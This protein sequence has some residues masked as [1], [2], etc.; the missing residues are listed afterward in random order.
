MKRIKEIIFKCS[1]GVAG[2]GG[3][4]DD[5]NCG[6]C[7]HVDSGH[8]GNKDKERLCRFTLGM[9]DIVAN[10]EAP[11]A[12]KVKLTIDGKDA[13]RTADGA[14][15]TVKLGR[16]YLEKDGRLPLT[17][18]TEP[19]DAAKALTIKSLVFTPA[20][21]G[22]PVV[23]SEDLSITL[24]ARDS[25]VHGRTL[26]YEY[27][28]DKNTLGYWGNEKDWV[29]WEFELKK[30]GKFIVFVMHGSGGGS[31]IEIA[32]DEQKLN[33]ITKIPGISH[34]Y[35]SRG[36]HAHSHQAGPVEPDFEANQESR[37][38]HHGSAA[39]DF[40]SSA[41]VIATRLSYEL[42]HHRTARLDSPARL[43]WGGRS[44]PDHRRPGRT[45]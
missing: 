28:P 35:V 2:G 10:L 39:G 3:G 45:R 9:F 42:S 27:R 40:D 8:S 15:A 22:K 1:A 25:I 20:P 18:E 32:V 26:R 34:L 13:A 11:A 31:E 38:R 17:I 24:Q 12:G 43:L 14:A 30:P 37:R 21:E 41:E 6:R 5:A 7:R 23:Q 16:V 36:R 44:I 33:W 29:S 19:A 4:Y